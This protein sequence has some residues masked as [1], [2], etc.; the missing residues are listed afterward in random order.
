MLI[1]NMNIKL[2]AKE[3]RDLGIEG[4]KEYLT[5]KGKENVD[6]LFTEWEEGGIGGGSSSTNART[7]ETVWT[8]SWS[9]QYG[10]GVNNDI[11]PNIVEKLYD[12]NVEKIKLHTTTASYILSKSYDYADGLMS[13]YSLNVIN[14]GGS[15]ERLQASVYKFVARKSLTEGISCICTAARDN[16]ATISAITFTINKIDILKY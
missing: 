1:Q 14:Q 7:W 15:G 12:P 6:D 3:K 8:G 5:S 11:A 9:T 13:E 16:G 2:N 10:E 4:L